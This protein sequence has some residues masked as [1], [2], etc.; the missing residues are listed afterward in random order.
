[1]SPTVLVRRAVQLLFLVAFVG[2]VAMTRSQ[3]DADPNPL[4]KLFFMF[5]P[6]VLVSTWLSAYAMPMAVFAVPVIA[7]IVLILALVR[8]WI[9]IPAV[10][11]AGLVL[12]AVGI[13]VG[14]VTGWAPM[15]RPLLWAFATI[16]VTMVLGRV[17]CGWICPLGTVHA[18]ASRLMRRRGGVSHGW[19]RWQ[20]AKYYLLAGLL[21]MA[22]LGGHWGTIFDPLV[23][24]YRTTTTAMFPAAQ[25][26]VEEGS[27]AVFQGQPEHGVY[28]PGVVTEPV[29]NYLRDN[30]FSIP[31]QAFL[32]SGL[33]AAFFVLTLVLNAYRPRFWCRYLCPLGAMLGLFSW[34]TLL[35]RKVD[36]KACNH[37]GLCD[38]T[39]HGA[40]A[41]KPGQGWMAAECLGCFHCSEA[42]P[43]GA[44]HFQA[45]LPW[46]QP[47]GTQS[48]DL[49]KR[50][51]L[52]AALGG[53]AG[54][55]LVRAT[56][57]ARGHVFHRR[58][59]RPPGA[60]D[61]RAFL[62]RCTA[63]GMC[64]K[65][66]PTGG[67]QPAVLEAGLEG[68]WTPRLVPSIGH[69]DYTCNLCGQVCPTE[70]IR[71]LTLDEKQQTKLGLA[72][73]DITRCIPYA[74]G[75][76][77]MVCEEHCPVPDKAIY[78][79]ETEVQDHDGKKTTIKQPRVDAKRCIGCGQCENVC[80][81]KD[82]PA[83]R[84]SSSNE[85]RQA[86]NQ[87]ILVGDDPDSEA[88]DSPYGS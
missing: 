84:V 11:F 70:A 32:G 27:T 34:R 66:C 43:R 71:P 55:A 29:Y 52:F 3:P 9:S 21:A 1:M 10:A 80:V 83:I 62:D 77:C 63:C 23:L 60:R 37:C 6:L 78:F 53:I 28:R 38:R 30:V 20:T 86:E 82:G 39:C 36:A 8:R 68:L 79:V 54:L 44:L 81:F 85:S 19:S 64:M 45:T 72:A 74:Y 7:A 15:P 13:I 14:Q 40:A 17:F 61:E 88:G 4:V 50:A 26:A 5:D 49:S 35:R 41:E 42:C 58:L 46:R 87:P 33:I 47:S 25:W 51:S 69:C 75:R 31:K 67:L 2:L 22:L 56:P 48:I 73:F 76:D 57:Q 24:L 65:V 18:I 59:I 12:A 16:A